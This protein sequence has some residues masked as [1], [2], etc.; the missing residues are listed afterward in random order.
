MR[1]WSVV[2]GRRRGGRARTYYELTERGVRA[3]EADR[4]ALLRLANPQ[5]P[6]LPDPDGGP[7]DARADRDRR[8]AERGGG[9]ALAAGTPFPGGSGRMRGKAG[10]FVRVARRVAEALGTDDCL[11]AGGLA[12]MAHGFVRGT[13][14]VDLLTRLPLSE[15]RVRLE[16]RR[17]AHSS[18]E[19]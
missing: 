11:L 17:P 4:A 7:A 3:S 19:G 1:S 9:R 12:V 6:L 13:R 5:S 10:R 2:P 8:G 14:D 18:P 15:A 16:A